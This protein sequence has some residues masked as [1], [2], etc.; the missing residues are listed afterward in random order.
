MPELIFRKYDLNDDERVGRKEFFAILDE[1][2]KWLK[3]TEEQQ[4]VI[5]N[6]ADSERTGW[7]NYREFL[8]LIV[9][10]NSEK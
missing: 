3:L 2:N 7:I 4:I 10:L 8:D 1:C 6:V 5:A 9:S